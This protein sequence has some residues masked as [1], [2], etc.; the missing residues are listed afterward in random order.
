MT[1][2]I[3]YQVYHSYIYP[4][5]KVQTKSARRMF[6]QDCRELDCDSYNTI[7][8]INKNIK[9]HTIVNFLKRVI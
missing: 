4:T 3:K 7:P 9:S 8:F 2:T 6:E 1:P 5:S